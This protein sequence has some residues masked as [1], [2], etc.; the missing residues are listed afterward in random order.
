MLFPKT[1]IPLTTLEQLGVDTI[2]VITD[3][4]L[5]QPTSVEHPLEICQTSQDFI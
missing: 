5:I 3:D 2:G 1:G 4:M